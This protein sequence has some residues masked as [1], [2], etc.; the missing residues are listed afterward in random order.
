MKD[1]VASKFDWEMNKILCV[2]KL[3]LQCKAKKNQIMSLLAC[4]GHSIKSSIII[5]L[6]GSHH[7]YV[8]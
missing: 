8:A 5:K 7:L 3:Y 2:Y 1:D 6:N 4:G